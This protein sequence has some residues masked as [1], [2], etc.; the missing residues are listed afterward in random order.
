MGFPSMS[1]NWSSLPSSFPPLDALPFPFA[2]GAKAE[3]LP[4]VVIQPMIRSRLSGIAFTCN[5]EGFVGE[6]VVVAGEGLGEGIV[7]DSVETATWH[8]T[9]GEAIWATGNQAVID[10]LDDETVLTIAELAKRCSEVIGGEADMEFAIA[11]DGRIY[12]LQAR[13]I[14]VVAGRPA[15][16]ALESAVLLDNS[17]IVESYPG[18]VLPLTQDFARDL[19]RRLFW[20]AAVRLSG[21]EELVDRLDGSLSELVMFSDWH[22]YYRISAWYD[23]LSLLPMSDRIKG[24]WRASLGVPDGMGDLGASIQVPRGTKA[25]VTRRFSRCIGRMPHMMDRA[26]DIAERVLSDADEA[27]EGARSFDDFWQV[28]LSLRDKIIPEWDV[29]LL[30]DA[31]T[32]MF[33]ALAGEATKVEQRGRRQLESMKPVKA[34]DALVATARISGPGSQAYLGAREEFIREYGDRCIGELKLETRTWRSSPKTLDALVR[35]RLMHPDPAS[36]ADGQ[37]RRKSVTPPRREAKGG[38]DRLRRM[39]FAHRAKEGTA[40]RERS[41]LLRTRM[42]GVARQA[43]L[44]CGEVLAEVGILES[45]R[46]VFYLGLDELRHAGMVADGGDAIAAEATTIGAIVS[47]RRERQ[48]I[49]TALPIPPRVQVVRG[50]PLDHSIPSWSASASGAKGVSVGTTL[51]GTGTSMGAATAEVLVIDGSDMSVDTKGKIL[52]T[53]STDPGWA[54]LISESAG[55]VAE[56]GSLLSHTAIISRELGIPAVVGIKGAT[57]MLHDGDTIRIDGRDGTVT[58]VGVAGS[59]GADGHEGSSSEGN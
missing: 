19:Y 2:S 35:S 34:L 59:D 58:V 37:P 47:D 3:G 49:L 9:D 51:R 48:R 38:R 31:N 32:F 56:R 46:D 40:D 28:Y 17:N 44:G 10:A 11:D 30:N 25:R 54:F 13:P 43:F 41:R 53:R 14:T 22:A 33:V 4:P 36:D 6:S 23:L 39:A 52:V 12:V 27:L 50:G 29:T 8:V 18:V 1:R 15:S 55:I 21:D 24:A 20:A 7:T 45:P 57:T 42:F 26:C 5:P 16:E